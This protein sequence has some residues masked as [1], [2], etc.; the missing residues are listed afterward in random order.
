MQK[1]IVL[2]LYVIRYETNSYS[3]VIYKRE[4]KVLE[5]SEITSE[6]E[7]GLGL[8][9]IG[10][11]EVC[12]VVKHFFLAWQHINGSLKVYFIVL[13]CMSAREKWLYRDRYQ[14]HPFLLEVMGNFSVI[15]VSLYTSWVSYM[16][17][18]VSYIF[19]CLSV[20]EGLNSSTTSSDW[21]R[22]D[23]SSHCEAIKCQWGKTESGKLQYGV[24]RR[25]NF[26]FKLWNVYQNIIWG[27]CPSVIN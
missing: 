21:H 7:V 19:P 17:D 11:F 23:G 26:A 3:S 10:Q 25:F 18:E 6:Y 12:H 2:S 4:K 27:F 15:A 1:D 9:E 22:W 14:E 20:I 8:S 5:I 24:H 16:V 13:S